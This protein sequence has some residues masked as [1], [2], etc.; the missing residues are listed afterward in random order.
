M[1]KAIQSALKEIEHVGW[2]G[3]SAQAP[4]LGHWN[5]KASLLKDIGAYFDDIVAREMQNAL[6]LSATPRERLFEVMMFRFD[7]L[8]DQRP[9]VRSIIHSAKADPRVGLMVLCALPGSMMRVLEIAGFRTSGLEG[10]IKARVLGLVW[11][12]IARVWMR[13]DSE[14][15]AETMAAL[16][17]ELTRVEPIGERLFPHDKSP[18]HMRAD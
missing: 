14:D 15:M 3:V 12:R 5:S 6:D 18:A 8:Q 10:R 2:H 11:L 16:D 7:A 17:K 4:V 13:D 1:N 9:A